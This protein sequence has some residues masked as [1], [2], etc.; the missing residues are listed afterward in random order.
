MRGHI[1]GFRCFL[2]WP[3]GGVDGVGDGAVGK[4]RGFDVSLGVSGR[5]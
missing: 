3:Y 4:F 2:D 5:D 1:R